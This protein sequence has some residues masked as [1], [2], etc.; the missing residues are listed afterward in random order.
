MTLHCSAFSQALDIINFVG[1]SHSNRY[2]WHLFILLIC[3]S[4]TA[5]DVEH[6]FYF[7]LLVKEIFRPQL[8]TVLRS[9]PFQKGCVYTFLVHCCFCFFFH[10][11]LGVLKARILKWFPMSFSSGPRFVRTLHHDPSILGGPTWHGS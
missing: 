4:L 10:T 8:H 7:W 3:N 2:I 6:L 9:D 1:F 5:N 11:G